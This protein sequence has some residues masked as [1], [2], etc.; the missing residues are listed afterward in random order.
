MFESIITGGLT[1]QNAL[2]CTA[3]SLLLGCIVAIV[4]KLQGKS[5]VNLFITLIVLP[6][7]VQVIIMLVNGNLGTGVAVAGAFSLIRFRSVPG[8]ARDILCIFYAMAIGLSTGMGYIWYAVIFTVIIGLVLVLAGNL[9]FFKIP[10][11]EKQLQVTI[12]EQLDYT[13]CFDDI[14]SAYTTQ[15]EL[16]HVKTTNMGT[17][18]QL[19][20]RIRLRDAKE[21]KSMLDAIRC[22]NGNLTVQCGH[23]AATVEAL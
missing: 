8:N 20:Y 7:I 14:F 10:K 18:F 15:A 1:M 12:P 4:Y 19:T 11:E 16:V 21:E 3:V 13:E 6:A 23:A 17:M 22:R 9:P 5:S 2:I